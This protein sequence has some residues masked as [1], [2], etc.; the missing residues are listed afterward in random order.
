MSRSTA[1]FER[2]RAFPSQRQSLRRKIMWLPGVLGQGWP[3]GGV[4]ADSSKAHRITKCI[5]R[6]CIDVLLEVLHFFFSPYQLRY[7]LHPCPT[8]WHSR[9]SFR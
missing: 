9:F 3:A 8:L 4:R 7:A 1:R 2:T 5:G 6:T